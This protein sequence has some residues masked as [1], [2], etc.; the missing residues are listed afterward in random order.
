[1]YCRSRAQSFAPSDQFDTGLSRAV[2]VVSAEHTDL[3]MYKPSESQVALLE[4]RP[5]DTSPRRQRERTRSRPTH[6]RRIATDYGFTA[7]VLE[8]EADFGEYSRQESM[9]FD[10]PPTEAR[11][12][13]RRH[14]FD[15]ATQHADVKV[16]LS[17]CAA[18]NIDSN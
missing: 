7:G 4:S 8:D 14:S 9:L 11:I 12:K 3:S 17:R 18:L 2:S 5:V 10:V 16:L 13:T 1:M 15:S 6:M